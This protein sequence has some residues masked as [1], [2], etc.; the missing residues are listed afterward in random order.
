MRFFLAAVAALLSAAAAVP[1]L[2]PDALWPAWPE[3]HQTLTT[4]LAEAPELGTSRSERLAALALVAQEDRR[5]HDRVLPLDVRSC[6]RAMLVNARE[7]AVRQGCSTLAMQ[8]AN[9]AVPTE[10]RYQRTVSRKLLQL[11]L[12]ASL[13]RVDPETLLA[14]YL[15]QLPCGSDLAVGFETCS[16]LWFGRPAAELNDTEATLLATAVQAPSRD[17]NDDEAARA[18]LIRVTATM[19]DLGWLDAATAR[20]IAEGPL[21]RDGLHPDLVRATLHGRD[22]DLS[23]ALEAALTAIESQVSTED[24]DDLLVLGAA[25]SPEGELLAY[26]GGPTSWL[27]R[28]IELG[29][30]AKPFCAQALLELGGTAYLEGAS[31][32]LKLPLRDKNLRAY[33][34]GN[35]GRRDLPARGA[36]ADWIMASVNTA[37]LAASLYVWTWLPPDHV[38]AHLSSLLRPDERRKWRT[39]KDRAYALQVAEAYA[40][41][42]LTHDDVPD[43][44]G[45]REMSVASVRACRAV[46]ERH[47]P[48]LEVPGEDL[49]AL[50]GVVR[51][52]LGELGPAFT[53]LWMEDGQTDLAALMARHGHV[54]TLKRTVASLGVPLTYKT[55]TAE[56]NAALAIVLPFEDAEGPAPV[57]LTFVALRPSGDDIDPYTSGTLA[58]GVRSFLAALTAEEDA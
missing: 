1:L 10:L 56:R 28:P 57:L 8:L 27:D 43:L 52:P 42:D 44:P 20:Q 25:W 6:A 35:A 38:E 58:L 4:W 19:T 40:G 17:L 36:P 55:A 26:A 7:G 45:Y 37:A 2:A 14:A 15:E 5:L 41:I 18:R 29:S 46:M 39:A 31:I 13:T 30:W 22:L 12:A 21:R 34:P 3:A 33:R 47:L 11:R 16:L 54:G 24:D 23:R 51:A 32:P 9:Q 48:S 49:A 50:L 53:E